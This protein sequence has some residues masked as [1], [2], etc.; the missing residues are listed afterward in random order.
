MEELK[1]KQAVRFEV[2]SYELGVLM[3]MGYHREDAAIQEIA[4]AMLQAIDEDQLDIERVKQ[5]IENE[6]VDHTSEDSIEQVVLN[7]LVEYF[8]ESSI[9]SDAI[10]DVLSDEEGT[11][12]LSE[13]SL[14]A[15]AFEVFAQVVDYKDVNPEDLSFEEIGEDLYGYDDLESS[16]IEKELNRQLQAAGYTYSVETC[17][18][19]K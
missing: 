16:N 4:E 7:V 2:L 1:M 10:S 19:A 15:W 12:F 5:G 11:A 9:I 18:W 17:R 8:K 13:A 3:A 6:L 14:A